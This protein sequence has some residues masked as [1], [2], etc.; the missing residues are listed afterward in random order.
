MPKS[1]FTPKTRSA[2]VGLIGSGNYAIVACRSVG[3]NEKTYYRWLEHGRD[4]L[5]VE[6]EGGRPLTPAERAYAQFAQDID[7]ADST[8]ET[9]AL[10]RLTEYGD[11]SR[12]WKE[13]MAMMERRWAARWGRGVASGTVVVEAGDGSG[14]GVEIKLAF[15]PPAILTD[16]QPGRGALHEEAA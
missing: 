11:E 7:Q 3:I 16:D 8:A 12:D 6:E 15:T 2:I 10:A 4:A 13:V 14:R 1:K 9:K 5:A